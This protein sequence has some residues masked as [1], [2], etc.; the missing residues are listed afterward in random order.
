MGIPLSF[1]PTETWAST[2]VVQQD[3]QYGTVKGTVK[4][5]KGEEMIGAVVYVV[6]TQNS[7]FVDFD[8]SYILNNVK[9]GATI[10]ATLMGFTCEDKIWNGGS[11]DFIMIEEDN[12]LEELV[13]TAM[14]IMR[15]EK[16]LTYATQMVKADDLFKAPDAN[17]I[18]SLEGKVSGITITPSAGGAGGASKITLRGNKSIMGDNAPL[19]VV[20]G[21]P[22]TNSIRG[23]IGDAA[24][25]TSGSNTEGSDPLSMINPDDIESMNV[26]KGA[27]AAALYGSRAANGVV[28]ITTK[29]GKEGKM[30]VTFNSSTTFDTPLITP[31]L[32][33]AYGGYRA[34][35]NTLLNN[36]W[37]DRLSGEG[38]HVFEYA[39]DKQYFQTTNADGTPN[40]LKAYL[41]NYANDDIADFFDTGINTTN[42]ISV[43]GGTEKIQTYA[44]YSNTHSIGMIDANRYNRNTFAFRQTYKLWDRI[45]LGV[46]V[47]YN[48]AK[49][50]NRVG[51]GT[52]GN[53]IYHLYT[54]PRD[55]D[56]E[57]YKD[58]YSAKG[59]WWSSGNAE[60]Q[61]TQNWFEDIG[62]LW[63]EH[64]DH[65]LLEGPM[66]QYA[67]QSPAINNPYWLKNMNF[68]TSNEERFSAS[69]NA[70]VKII[71]GLNLQA[72]VSIDHSKYQSE[73][74]RYATTWYD[75]EMYRY[76]T[77]YLD[78]SRTNE[79][80]TDYMLSYNKEFDKDW[81]LSAT[82]GYVG[83][84]IK[85]TSTNTYIGAATDDMHRGGVAVGIPTSINMFE[86]RY[87]GAG[88]TNKGTSSNWDQA[89]L[90]TA[91]VGWKDFLFVDASYRQDW[92]RPF[93]QF[94]YL[95]TDESY[96]YFGVGANAILSD[97]IKLPD[98]FTY[99]KYRLSYSEVGNS[100]PNVL[101]NSV[102]LN[103]VLGTAGVS[104]RNFFIPEP[105][106]TKSF[107]TGLEM[108]FFN[109]CLNFDI[110]YYNS[111]MHKS[112][113]EVAGTNG[114][115]QPVNSGIIR[116]QGI[117]LTVGYDWKINRDWRWKTSANFS[118]NNNEIEATSKDKWGNH[119]DMATSFAEGKIQLLYRKGG[120]YGDLYITD[121]TRY[122]SDVYKY[123]TKE[124]VII[125]RIPTEVTV[126]KYS[127]TPVTD[128][129][130]NVISELVNKKGDLY[131][132]NGKPSLGG[133]VSVTDG[134][135]LRVRDSNKKF[136]KF[137]GNVNS[138]YQLSWSNT[139]TYKDFSL[140]FLINGRIGGKVV[141]LTEGYLDEI[142]ASKRS[143]AARLNAE[144]NSIYTEDGR[145]G[146]YINEG[147]N[148]V[149]IE[150]Y[151]TFVGTSY[152]GD[153]IY[154]ATNFRL[155][156]L[157]LG[158]TFRN[159]FGEY[160]NLN[161]SLV[162]RNLFFLYKDSPV[163]PDVSLS[164]A[165]GLGGIDVFNYPSARSFGLNIKVNL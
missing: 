37:G 109:D 85:G 19:I 93:R 51:G 150:D 163:D 9:K 46:N 138:K 123:D 81:T 57:Y 35:N 26:L 11:L 86:P 90:V 79:I 87:G 122:N 159:L 111:A 32:Q 117:E 27:N 33:N 160:K 128:E 75:T 59:Q 103:N 63:L 58:N 105:E 110:T 14:G 24:T 41:R 7:A 43:S 131:I 48:Q 156:E 133:Y 134:G 97:V 50:K 99:A 78:N 52:L 45:T 39:A 113:L 127:S 10:R 142:G 151:Y 140:Y 139:F 4:S 74:G 115:S 61:G 95:G 29:K 82:A 80:Y 158:Y 67:F 68:G 98:W 120:A 106:K 12:Q 121:F 20:D 154:D 119:K 36:S 89:A 108:Q 25:L 92:Y 102:S 5:D 30:E 34:G 101:Y 62:G 164:T 96:G 69:F 2:T 47:N 23:Q 17:L 145:L 147:R 153:Y 143:G 15:K 91:Q 161:I 162:C 157:S 38:K 65:A 124:T 104:S 125:D 84:T 1:L 112:Y 55:V 16:S 116:N 135:K 44:S 3:P 165:N 83:H 28:M 21:V 66:Q 155:R 49:T 148:L 31:E 54:A 129:N 70:T 144:K 152:V 88:V 126:T 18:N 72:R 118:Y 130:G 42:S 6:G 114:K 100:I 13:V 53:P 76:G 94:A 40:M 149:S 136:Q 71:E 141:S 56:M 107:E 73:G 77:Y 8:G 132:T 137:A 146:M 64:R 60:G 22:M